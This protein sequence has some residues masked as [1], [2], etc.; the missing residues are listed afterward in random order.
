MRQ[1]LLANE[2]TLG[3]RVVG[4]QDAGMSEGGIMQ[5]LLANEITLVDRVVGN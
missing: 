1:S 3:D 4:S 2:I 5:D